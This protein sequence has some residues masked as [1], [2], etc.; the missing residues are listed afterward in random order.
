MRKKST[1][2]GYLG[3]CLAAA[4]CLGGILRPA[5]NPARTSAAG[6]S[7]VTSDSIKAKEAQIAQK[8]KEKDGLKNSL[9]DLQKIKK[10]LEAQ[11]DDLQKYVAQ[12]DQNLAQIEQH[13]AE[14]QNEISIK[15]A[16]IARTEEEL[17]LALEMEKNQQ[18][19]MVAH[20]RLMYETGNTNMVALLL[21]SRSLSEFLNK[22]DYAEK[23]ASYDQQMW[24][25]Y[26]AAREYVELCKQE[27]ELA[28]EILNETRAGVEAEQQAVE[29]LI[30]Q[31]TNDILSYMNDIKKKEK[32]IAEY[33]KEIKAE[34]EEIKM[35]EEA[36]AE[37]RRQ[38]LASSML[39]YDGGLFKFPMAMYT[40]MT[41]D[42]GYRKD[43][44]TG[45]QGFHSGIDFAAPKGT[46]IYAAYNGRVVAAAYSVSMGNYVMIDHGDGLYTIYMHASALYVNKG[47]TVVR[48]DTIAAVGTTGRSTGN[49]LHFS[50]RLNG[51]YV[52]PWGYLGQAN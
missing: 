50:V 27:L 22:A 49:H 28:K 51:A 18:E 14:L 10:S 38:L 39:K 46:A 21:G 11:K 26:K 1:Y 25:S 37:E 3:I 40:K 30:E 4:L 42:F 47:D 35:L 17:A 2:A 34:E 16:E 33:E 15:E 52:S 5:V 48:G 6:L 31:K 29:A 12:L 45:A 8:Q 44:F 19:A 41:S 13:I 32:A 20:I 9:S 36:V 43:P 7:S 24:R 23:V